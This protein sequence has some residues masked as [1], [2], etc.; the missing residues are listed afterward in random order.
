MKKKRFFFHFR[1]TTGELTLHWN[2]QCISIKNIDCK[3]PIETKWNNQQP[4]IVLRGW[5]TNV[6]FKNNKAIIT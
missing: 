3:V 2:K 6:I 5:A 1:K 4:R